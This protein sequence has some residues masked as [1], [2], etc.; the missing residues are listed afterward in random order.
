[1]ATVLVAAGL[2]TSSQAITIGSSVNAGESGQ[3]GLFPV[4]VDF[5]SVTYVSDLSNGALRFDGSPTS[6]STSIFTQ[7]LNILG[8]SELAF[9]WTVMD[10]SD[11][12]DFAWY[13]IE[14]L[15]AG[16]STFHDGIGMG[17]SAG[18]VSRFVS[19]GDYVLRIQSA[20]AFNREL[21]KLTVGNLRINPRDVQTVSNQIEV[22][23]RDATE[24]P[25]SS[26]GFL[27]IATI[28]ALVGAQRRFG[29]KKGSA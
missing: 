11:R 10:L 2:A 23:Q 7:T 22:L 18:T 21:Y 8:D 4:S 27:G 3:L 14:G 29:I 19:T 12:D 1:M 13:Q 28:F 6:Q 15:D 9:D 20:V 24:V 17:N 16:I 26:L 25:D 5:G